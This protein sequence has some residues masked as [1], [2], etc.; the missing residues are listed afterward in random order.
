MSIKKEE[1]FVYGMVDLTG[2][3]ETWGAKYVF[4]ELKKFDTLAFN[5]C[6]AFF[7]ADSDASRRVAALLRK[8]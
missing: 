8:F 3:I 4:G 1:G 2:F 7:D 6:K 5:D